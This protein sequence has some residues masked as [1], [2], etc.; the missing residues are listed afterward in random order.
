MKTVLGLLL[1]WLVSILPLD[2]NEIE[3]DEQNEV[4]DVARSRKEI[5][6]ALQEKL[7]PKNS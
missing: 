3:F 6:L 5:F 1:H 4:K 7:D 2:K